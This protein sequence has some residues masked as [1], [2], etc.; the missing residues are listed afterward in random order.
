MLLILIRN[1]IID[2]EFARGLSL[3]ARDANGRQTYG[4]CTDGLPTGSSMGKIQKRTTV[5][6]FARDEHN[7][8]DEKS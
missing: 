8:T 1:I 6:R 2:K 5:H 4:R 7:A 3:D